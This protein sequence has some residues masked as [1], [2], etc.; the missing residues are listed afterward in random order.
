MDTQTFLAN[1]ETIAEAPAGIESLRSLVLDL[2][3]RGR[4]VQQHSEVDD[5]RSVLDAVRAESGAVV[6]AKVPGRPIVPR[7][8]EPWEHRFEAP[9]GW[10]WARIDDT[11]SYVNGLAFNQHTWTEAGIPIVRIQNL[12]NPAAE[13]NYA[14]GPFPED[15]MIDEGDILVSWSATLEAFVWDRGPAVLNQHIFKVIPDERLVDRQFLFYLLRSSIRAL[16]AGEAAHGLVMKHINRGPF[17]CFPVALPPLEEQ[18]RIVA[19]FREL[20]RMFDELEVA[21]HQRDNAAARLAKSLSVE[22]L[23]V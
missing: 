9:R 6:K 13:F 17:I 11:G 15:R 10:E 5:I 22:R 20:E 12:T 4:L 1:F 21:Q 2:A 7:V 23:G 3:V 16:A 8:P 14:E 18:R 19:K